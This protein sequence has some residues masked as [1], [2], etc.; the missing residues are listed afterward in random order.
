MA[1]VGPYDPV[2]QA[3]HGSE[4][5]IALLLD[6]QDEITV[7]ELLVD[8]A[9]RRRGVVSADWCE[10]MSGTIERMRCKAGARLM[11]WQKLWPEIHAAVMRGY[12]TVGN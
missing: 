11:D 12:Q 7:A 3:L 8:Q 9:K 6:I 1:H 4:D 2:V 10:L 5:A